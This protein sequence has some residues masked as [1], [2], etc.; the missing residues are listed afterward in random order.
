MTEA[1]KD[2]RGVVEAVGVWGQRWV[3][4]ELSLD[5]LDPS[6]LM[7]DMRRNLN[8]TPMPKRRCVIEFQF[9][10][11]IVASFLGGSLLW[12]MADANRRDLQQARFRIPFIVG[13][14]PFVWGVT[15]TGFML[16]VCVIHLFLFLTG[17][18]PTLEL[19]VEHLYATYT[20]FGPD[21]HADV[22]K[23]IW[24]SVRWGLYAALPIGIVMR[25]SL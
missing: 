17:M 22:S 6:L 19:L 11:F 1:G 24:W 9:N 13:T 25:W 15:M 23:W 10:S 18:N 21:Y 5:N 8:T 3:D 2:L 12:A 7:W 14:V 4:A 16:V 20:P